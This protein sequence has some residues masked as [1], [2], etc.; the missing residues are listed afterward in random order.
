MTQVKRLSIFLASPSDVRQERAL[1]REVIDEVNRTVAKDKGVVLDLSSSERAIPGYGKDGQTIINEQLGDMKQYDLFVGIMWNRIG[2][3]TPRDISGTAEEF[4]RAVNALK[5]RKKPQIWFYFRDASANLKTPEELDQKAGVL[6]FRAKLRGNGLFSEYTTLQSFEK[7]FREHLI[8]WLNTRS[9]KATPAPQR[10]RQRSPG[11]GDDETSTTRAGR[12]TGAPPT[13]VEPEPAPPRR[14]PVG[15][16]P[17]KR[18][19]DVTKSPGSWI[20]LDDHFYQAKSAVVQADRSVVLQ[21]APPAGERTTDL[22][23]LQAADFHRRRDVTYTDLHEAG[24]TQVQSI[25]SETSKGKT[26]FTVTLAPLPQIN[27]SNVME[28]STR[29]YTA[30]QIAELRARLILLGQPFPKE[31]EFLAITYQ[32]RSRYSTTVTSIRTLPQLWASLHTQSRLFL[33]QAWLYAA[34]LLKTGNI[35]ENILTLELGTIK[36]KKMHVRFRGRR[37]RPYSSQEPVTISI[38]GD[39]VLEV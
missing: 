19:P 10:R 39:C 29:G 34:Y 15:K 35:V 20:M 23:S 1:V 18:R 5:R 37:A 22:R 16:A 36:D 26:I 27:T 25:V 38:E 17:V 24:T 3:P 28:V 21:I 6:R 2:T 12:S 30:D 33:P 32:T 8:T 11:K 4:A 31:I 9:Q 7:K 14:S 13:G